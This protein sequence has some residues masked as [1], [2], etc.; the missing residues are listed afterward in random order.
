MAI[1]SCPI[2]EERFED[3]ITN[4]AAWYSIQGTLQDY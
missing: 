4:G 2:D 1:E 3:G